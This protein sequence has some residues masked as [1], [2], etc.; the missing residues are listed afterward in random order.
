MQVVLPEIQNDDY[1]SIILKSNNTSD[2]LIKKLKS[3]KT[4][5]KEMGK[6]N[7]GFYINKEPT[8]SESIF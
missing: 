3:S 8:W 4:A 2:N 6:D 5:E 1:R 7:I